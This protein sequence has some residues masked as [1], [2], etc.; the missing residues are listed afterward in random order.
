MI[1]TIACENIIKNASILYK[2]KKYDDLIRGYQQIIEFK[3]HNGS[4]S[5]ADIYLYHSNISY[6][7]HILRDFPNALREATKCIEMRPQWYK[8]YYRAA[9]ASE[10]MLDTDKAKEY[11]ASMREMDKDGKI[12]PD[13]KNNASNVDINILREWLINN[14]A[15][16]SATKIEYY[17]VDY[18]GMVVENPVKADENIIQIPVS[19]IF[20][21][22]ESKTRG[23]NKKLLDLGATY[24]SPHTHMALDLLDAKYDPDS[25]YKYYINCLPKYFDNVPINFS[26]E[27]LK[28]LEGSYA[29]VKIAQKKHYMQLEYDGIV[30]LMAGFPYSYADFNWARTCIITRVYAVERDI[31]DQPVKDNVLVPFADMANHV[32]T[33][34][35]HWFFDKKMDSFIVKAVKYLSPGDNLFESYGKKCNYRYFVNYGFTM[36]NNEAEEVVVVLNPIARSII[37]HKLYLV[38]PAC[39]DHINTSKEI[40]QIGYNKEADPY[41]NLVQFARGKC[42]EILNIPTGAPTN[43]E[44][45]KFLSDVMQETLNGFDTSLEEDVAMLKTYALGFDMR[46]CIIQ[47]I[48]EKKILHHYIDYFKDT[49]RAESIKDKKEKKKFMK[50]MEKKYCIPI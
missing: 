12:T 2:N 35:T 16:L 42:A 20:S 32:M 15:I 40:F 29:L 41:K 18:R 19:C 49:V 43:E 24:N 4:A 47:R 50:K 10:G 3:S 8:G 26:E 33:S 31:N 30:K 39:L 7:Y 13:E 9:R 28:H 27:K 17:D 45:Y 5:A 1:D 34:N 23:T 22:E 37:S 25:K 11:Y 36:E 46:N 48:G 38:N 6:I 44:V 21:L 14:G